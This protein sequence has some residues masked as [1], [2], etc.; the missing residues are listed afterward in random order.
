MVELED[1]KTMEAGAVTCLLTGKVDRVV[2]IGD[3]CNPSDGGS[4]K[5]HGKEDGAEADAA[6]HDLGAVAGAG[7]ALEAVPGN[8]A[9]PPPAKA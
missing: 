7:G 1:V 5:E 6:P 3:A 2:I 9:K 8:S 4:D